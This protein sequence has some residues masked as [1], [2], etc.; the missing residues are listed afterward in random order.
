MSASVIDKAF[1][2]M[3]GLDFWCHRLRE[4]DNML[5]RI[6][7]IAPILCLAAQ[8]SHAQ[9]F[10]QTAAFILSGGDVELTD[11]Q[12][13]SKGFVP[14]PHTYKY[15]QTNPPMSFD[16]FR[17]LRIKAD[18]SSCVVRVEGDLDRGKEKYG[19]IRE[20][21]FSSVILGETRQGDAWR[22]PGKFTVFTGENP[23]MCANY[24]NESTG[25][26]ICDVTV[27]SVQVYVDP[28]KQTRFEKAVAYIYSKYCKAA[29]RK[30]AF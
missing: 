15:F 10:A 28:E 6:S 27:K 18:E 20:F 19:A 13:D 2:E 4:G 5:G 29:T 30:S 23:L 22:A 7:W 11:V 24:D 25:R 16:V 12:Q 3:V 1:A 9:T 26:P 17:A 21:N 8:P 14:W